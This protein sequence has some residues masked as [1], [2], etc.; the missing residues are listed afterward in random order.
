MMRLLVLMMLVLGGVGFCRAELTAG[1]GT[2]QVL[3]QL[4]EVGK[5]L[6]SF[7]ANVV[8]REKDIVAQDSSSRKGFAVYQK[9]D[10]GDAR[11]RISFATRVQDGVTQQQQIDYLL[12]NG[13]LID[14]NGP[15]KIEIRRQ[16]LQPGEKANLLKLGEGP[17]PLPIGQTR[18]D[19]LKAFDVKKVEAAKDD[20]PST[21]HVQLLP[22][23]GTSFARKF[24]SIDVW[25]DLATGMPRRVE[26]MDPNETMR[27][28]ADFNELKINVPVQEEQ[29]ALPPLPGD[30]QRRE[31]AYND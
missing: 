11:M 19:V 3:D 14:R 2:D 16:M 23:D 13:L 12:D 18:E 25:V 29:F 30:W 26:T 7:T 22:K 9:K 17:F 10:N 31:E 8:L 1:S 15:R 4:Y 27:R 6:K 20:P 5:D 24:Q 21:V 28:G